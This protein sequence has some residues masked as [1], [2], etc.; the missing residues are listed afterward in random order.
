MQV[1]IDPTAAQLLQE[2][3]AHSAQVVPVRY[4][5]PDVSR[6]PSPTRRTSTRSTN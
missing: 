1:A 6:S 2:G 5:S 3:F 4:V